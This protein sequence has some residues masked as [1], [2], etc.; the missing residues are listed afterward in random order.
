MASGGAYYRPV[1]THAKV[2]IVDDVWWTAGSANLNS[3]GLRSDAEINVAALDAT[4]A[5]DL[6]LAL[7]AEHLQPANDQLHDLLDPLVGLAALERAALDNARRIQSGDPLSGHILPYLTTTDAAR[8][9]FAVHHEHGW[10]D[11]LPGGAGALPAHHA[12]RYL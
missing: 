7:W 11:A 2:A 6:R 4:V 9:G 1:Y 12:E 10:L 3:R 5:H 8:S